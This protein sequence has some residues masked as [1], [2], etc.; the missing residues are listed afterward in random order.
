MP[1]A[2]RGGNASEVCMISNGG[3]RVDM[4]Q[5][6]VP[7]K[8]TVV[9]FYADWCGPCRRMGPQ[10]EEMALTDPDITLCKIDVVNWDTDVVKQFSIRSI[11]NVLVYDRNGTAVGAPSSGLAEIKQNIQRAR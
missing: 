5:V 6:L 8:V 1:P 11:P 2:S 9:D 4:K 10:L 7:G 3:K